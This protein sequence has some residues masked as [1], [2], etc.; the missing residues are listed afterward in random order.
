MSVY[1]ELAEGASL[2]AD[3]G[4]LVVCDGS[5]MDVRVSLALGAWERQSELVRRVHRILAGTRGEMAPRRVGVASCTQHGSGT[6]SR[7][8]IKTCSSR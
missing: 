8:S 5:R 4:A 2:V 3:P 1:A 6:L 7:S